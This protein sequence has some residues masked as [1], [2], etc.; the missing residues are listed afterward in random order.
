MADTDQNQDENKES[1]D[2]SAENKIPDSDPALDNEATGGS[3]VADDLE[4]QT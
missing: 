1:A 4:D 2:S 3:E